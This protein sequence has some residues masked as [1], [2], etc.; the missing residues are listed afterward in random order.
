[1][2]AFTL[3]QVEPL[4]ASPS[5]RFALPGAEELNARLLPAIQARRASQPGLARSNQHGWHS[6]Y[7]LFHWEEP[8]FR[9]LCQ[10]FAQAVMAATKHVAPNYEF[11]GRSLQAEGW[12]NI[13]GQHAYNTPHDHAGWAWSGSYYV[14]VPEAQGRSGLF[15][16]LDCRTNANVVGIEGAACFT[17]KVPVTPRAGL[18]MLFPA[19]LQHWVYPNEQ[20]A[21]RISIAFNA[22]FAPVTLPQT[23]AQPENSPQAVS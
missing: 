13:N 16:F 11:R 18:L 2:V 8:V 17:A 7:Q 1:M 9:E 4:F 14:Q 6:D 5:F 10:A 22:R 12:V 3:S 23:T 20:P 21:E 15:E 19:Y